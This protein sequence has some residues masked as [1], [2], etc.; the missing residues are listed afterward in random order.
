MVIIIGYKYSSFEEYIQLNYL[1]EITE[2]ME[3]GKKLGGVSGDPIQITPNNYGGNDYTYYRQ[4]RKGKPIEVI[5][6]EHFTGHPNRGLS[7]HINVKNG[8]D[9]MDWHIFF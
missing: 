1:D 5:L 3:M 9:S 6:K 8:L 4:I 2:A 7:R